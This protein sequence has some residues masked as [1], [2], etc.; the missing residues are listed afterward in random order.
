M[1]LTTRTQH[2]SSALDPEL[3]DFTLEHPTQAAGPL[4]TNKPVRDIF[5]ARPH[6]QTVRVKW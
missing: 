1:P 3:D 4:Y 5:L 2:G 6:T